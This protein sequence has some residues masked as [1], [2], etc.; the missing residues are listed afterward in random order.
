[1][2]TGACAQVPVFVDYR[3]YALGQ[4]PSCNILNLAPLDSHFAVTVVMVFVYMQITCL[5]S[6]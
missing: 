4:L 2:S 5:M 3:D 1:M 6:G